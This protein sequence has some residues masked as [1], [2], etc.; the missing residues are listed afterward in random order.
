MSP[1]STHV[2]AAAA[3]VT[4]FAVIDDATLHREPGSSIGDYATGALVIL[5]AIGLS[6]VFF[7]RLRTGAQAALA[8]LLGTLAIAFGAP[9]LVEVQRGPGSAWDAVIGVLCV[10][11]GVA[12]IA[13]AAVALWTSRKR[14]GRWPWRV[15]RRGLIA[16]GALLAAFFLVVPMVF[17]VVLT[18][19]PRLDVTPPDL[20]ARYDDV[21]LPTSDGLDLAGWYLPPK[22]GAVVITFPRRTGAA[23]HA[24]MLARHGYGVLLVDGRGYD[25]SEGRSNVFGWGQTKDLDAAVD[26]LSSRPEVERI[27]GLGLSVGGEQLLEAAA[28]DERLDAVVADGAGFRTAHEARLAYGTSPGVLQLAITLGIVRVLSPESYPEPLDRLVQKISPRAVMFIEAEH[29][30]GGEE[31]N[32]RYHELAGQ[33]KVYWKVPDT[34]HT[35]GLHTHPDEYERRVI[36]FLDRYLLGDT[37]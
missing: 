18:H 9:H 32:T 35:Q 12:A 29:G 34:N 37:S 30:M 4:A 19:R 20:G 14:E 22:N 36:A 11:A 23:D 25:R 15:V 1:R 28:S 10:V 31:N 24:R 5:G 3:A 8:I 6:A 7:R 26:F 17:G 16:V 21:A 33:P 13:V 27:G 2:V